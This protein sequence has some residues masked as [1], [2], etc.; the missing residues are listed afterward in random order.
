MDRHPAEDASENDSVSKLPFTKTGSPQNRSLSR[1]RDLYQ[2]TGRGGA[3]NIRPASRDARPADGPDDFSPARGRERI[4]TDADL[5][6]GYTTG[7]GGAGN[8]RSPSRDGRSPLRAEMRKEIEEEEL[9]IRAE[10]ADDTAP[11]STGRGGL[12]NISRSRSRGPA[13]TSP[14]HSTGRGGMGNI[15]AGEGVLSEVIDDEELRKAHHG[16]GIHHTGRGGMANITS[17]HEDEQ[18][19]DVPHGSATAGRGGAGNIGR[20]RS[21]ER[22]DN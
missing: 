5:A 1:G 22:N 18:H 20:S 6:R 15:I 4:L 3:G 17:A 14:V 9:V 7:R 16:D 10:A 11:H 19:L 12:G 2:S 8:I 13:L 21:S